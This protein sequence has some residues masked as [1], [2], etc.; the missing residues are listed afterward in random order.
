[1]IQWLKKHSIASLCIVASII[2]IVW[3]IFCWSGLWGNPHSTWWGDVGSF[4]GGVTAPITGMLSAILLYL[5]F[6]KQHD[7]MTED[8]TRVRFETERNKIIRDIQRVREQFELV[9]QYVNGISYSPSKRQG[10]SASYSGFYALRAM[11]QDTNYILLDVQNHT[12]F[13]AD[14]LESL[15]TSLDGITTKSDDKELKELLQKE[16]DALQETIKLYVEKVAIGTI[17]T[18]LASDDLEKLKKSYNIS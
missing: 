17:S 6:Q 18:I 3:E 14:V 2:A 11:N 9:L 7:R 13:I 1:M 16:K 8:S 4:I 10:A 5:T 15:K 12:R